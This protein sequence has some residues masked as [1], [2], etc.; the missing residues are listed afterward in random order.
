V[1]PFLFVQTSYLNHRF[2]NFRYSVNGLFGSAV[3]PNRS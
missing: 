2:G 1:A 3:N